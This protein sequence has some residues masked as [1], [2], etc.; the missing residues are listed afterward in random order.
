MKTKIN[1]NIR[2]RRSRKGLCLIEVLM[3]LAIMAILLTA[4]AVAFD[5]ALENYTVN[6]DLAAVSVAARNALYQMNYIIRTAWNDPATDVITVNTPGTT[7]S[8]VDAYGRNVVYSYDSNAHQLKVSV[9]GGTTY[10]VMVENVYPVTVGEQIFRATTDPPQGSS[11]PPD[12]VFRVE[13][14]FMVSQQ[15]VTRTF[16]QAAVPRNVLYGL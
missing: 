15:G 2:P 1:H 7:C 10:Y 11:F 12:T 5:A 3:S 16:S 6:H 13:I 14:R 8:L 9:D 4:T